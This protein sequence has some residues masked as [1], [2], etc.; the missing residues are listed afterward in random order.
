MCVTSK[1]ELLNYI[2]IIKLETT[3]SAF[4]NIFAYSYHYGDTPLHQLL[5]E[6]KT[7]VCEVLTYSG[8]NHII[9]IEHFYNRHP[10][11]IIMTSYL[12]RIYIY[13][14]DITYIYIVLI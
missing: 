13:S 10:H 9:I 5:W 8:T 11:H 3:F 7:T 12:S 1:H 4:H 14:I 6:G 2:Y